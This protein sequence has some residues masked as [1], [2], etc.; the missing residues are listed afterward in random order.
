MEKI[1]IRES[2][3]ELLKIIAI[4]LIIISHV[5]Q[6]YSN[7]NDSILNNT[8]LDFKYLII[9]MMRHLGVL[10]NLIFIICTSWFLIGSKK[11]N[12]KKIFKLIIEIFVISIIIL[13][14]FLLFGLNITKSDIIKSCLPTIFANNWYITCYIL[15][16]MIVPFLN[17]L[18]EKIERKQLLRICIVSVCLYWI[19]SAIVSAF[20]INELILFITIFFIIAYIKK[21]CNEFVLNKKKNIILLFISILAFI[22]LILATNVLGSKFSFLSKKALYWNK[23]NN[24]ILL[25]NAIALFNLFKNF[26][27]KNKT[28]NYISS[29]TLYIYI[30]HENLLVRNYLRINIW[31]WIGE[32]FTYNN[33]II[34]TLIYAVILFIV[35]LIISI[36]YKYTIKKI[37]D[38]LVKK[39]YNSKLKSIYKKLENRL[40]EIK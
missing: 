35:S 34:E 20:F 25:L 16:L 3:I 27:F 40:L 12:K 23:N 11:D 37:I 13:I 1:K 17:I 4:F 39:I 22:I 19:I 21:Y 7:A 9:I 29:L 26:K 18:L 10:G 5:V 32:K 33:L 8:I 2:G 28:I 15:F 6:S 38:V 36:I 30:I 14:I 24:I 31:K